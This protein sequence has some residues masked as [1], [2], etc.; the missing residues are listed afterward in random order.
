MSAPVQ[1]SFPFS[2]RMNDILCSVRRAEHRISRRHPQ[3]LSRAADGPQGQVQLSKS[4]KIRRLNRQPGPP[5]GGPFCFQT[6][7]VSYTD[8][9]YSMCRMLARRYFHEME[10][11]S[12][13][14]LSNFREV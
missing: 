9:L 5:M 6:L 8:L 1:G 4:S 13:T 14:G 3:Q 12:R 11:I 10:A 2:K 7:I